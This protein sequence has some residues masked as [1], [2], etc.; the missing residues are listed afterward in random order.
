MI[1]HSVYFKFRPE[2]DAASRAQHIT[3]FAAL[4]G[5]IS[6]IAGYEAGAVFAGPDAKGGAEF[7]VAHQVLFHDRDGLEAYIPHPAHREFIDRNRSIW[8]HVLVVDAEIG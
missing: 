1:R 5:K 6:A 7:D 3:D 8:E 4:P 2:T